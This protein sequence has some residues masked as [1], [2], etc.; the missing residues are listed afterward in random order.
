MPR[1]NT[2]FGSF[3]PVC[4]SGE[5]STSWLNSSD[6]LALFTD[7]E[8]EEGEGEWSADTVVV[9][10]EED[11]RRTMQSSEEGAKVDRDDGK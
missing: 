1:V 11:H 5:N 8:D 7:E 6:R 9:V 2:E 10:E 4:A 3:D